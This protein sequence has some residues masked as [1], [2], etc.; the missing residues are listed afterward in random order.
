MAIDY[1]ALAADLLAEYRD[2]TA[3]YQTLVN[4]R[5]RLVTALYND[6]WTSSDSQVF[7]L[8]PLTKLVKIEFT[9]D[10]EAVVSPG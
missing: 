5:Q 4:Q 8:E 7:D 1:Q 2:Q 3:K 10:G 9:K 6:A